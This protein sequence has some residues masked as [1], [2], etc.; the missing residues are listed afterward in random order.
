MPHDESFDDLIGIPGP[1]VRSQFT[2]TEQVEETTTD[3]PDDDH[4]RFCPN[5]H[6]VLPQ[7]ELV[8]QDDET[9]LTELPPPSEPG[10]PS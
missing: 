3:Q 2:D 5:C 6:R 8:C 1:N 10:S 9:A 7:T 4:S